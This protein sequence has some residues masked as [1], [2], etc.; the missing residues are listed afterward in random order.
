M[1]RTP[2]LVERE[3]SR[4]V[5]RFI[6]TASVAGDLLLLLEEQITG[7]QPDL[8]ARL[9]LTQRQGE[10]LM[11]AMKGLTN[12]EIADALFLSANTVRKHFE[13]IYSKLGVTSRGQAVA[14]ALLARGDVS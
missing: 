12:H 13:N 10:V 2:L 11:L 4:L 7:I 14:R 1:P 6:G 9:G 3:A 5:L 8:P